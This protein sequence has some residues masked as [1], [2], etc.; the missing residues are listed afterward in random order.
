MRRGAPVIMRRGRG[1]IAGA[2]DKTLD[3]SLPSFIHCASEAVVYLVLGL[4]AAICVF[5][6]Y[7]AAISSIKPPSEYVGPAHYV[8]LIDFQPSLHAWRQLLIDPVDNTPLRF[9]NTVVVS[10]GATFFTVV[11]G[12][13]A[14]YGL[15]RSFPRRMRLPLLYAALW[16]RI[17]PP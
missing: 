13:M 2:E 11:F 7:W 3:P 10:S 17:L 4:W 16:T 6:L 1:M 9:L 15:E 12:A 8:P 5:P 14:A